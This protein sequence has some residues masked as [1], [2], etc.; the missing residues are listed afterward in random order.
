MKRKKPVAPAPVEKTAPM[1]NAA[2]EKKTGDTIQVV[3]FSVLLFLAMIAQTG[4]MALILTALALVAALPVGGGLNRLRG[5]WS[6]PVL[7]LLLFAVMNGLAAIY[8]PFDK[9]AVMEFYKILSAV[10]LSVILLCRFEKKHV[11]G[12]LWGVCAVCAA[13]ALLCIDVGAGRILFAPFNALANLFGDDYRSVLAASEG[14]RNNGIYNDANITGGIL[15]LATLLGAYLVRTTETTR[16]KV[17]ACLLLGCTAMGLLL[18]MS[19]GALLCFVLSVLVYLAV[20]R[21]QRLR[22][23]LQWAVTA[24]ALVA[25]GLPAMVLMGGSSLPLLLALLCGGV[26]FLLDWALGDRLERVLLAHKKPAW[27]GAVVLA[28]VCVAVCVAAFQMTEPYTHQDGVNFDRA[29]RLSAGE[30]TISGDWDERAYARI[31]TATHEQTLTN[32]VELLFDGEIEQARFV[33]AEDGY[34]HFRLWGPAGTQLREVTLSDGTEIPLQYTLIPE[35]IISRMQGGLFNSVSFL[36]RAQY[37][38]DALTLFAQSPLMGH[39][40]AS[41]EGLYRSVQPFYYESIYVHN[42]VLQIMSDMGLLGLAAFLLVL[43]GALW[44]LLQRL[45]TEHDPL[46]AVLIAC[47]VMMNAHGLMEINFSIQAFQ[48]LA[49][50]LLLLPVV[51]YAKPLAQG[52]VVKWVSLLTAVLLWL[53]LA[54]FGFLVVRHQMVERESANLSTSIASNFMSST[55]RFVKQDVFVQEQNKLNFIANAVILQNPLYQSNMNRWV[56][57]LREGGTYTACSGLAKHYYLPLGQYG[58]MFE[59]SR[60]GIAQVASSPD[61]WNL[62]MNFYRTEVLPAMTGE[63][64]EIYLAGVQALDEA[65]THYNAGRMEAVSLNEENAKFLQSVSALQKAGIGGE[66]ALMLLSAIGGAA[67]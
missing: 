41:T 66:E 63:T 22:L 23:F 21:G 29:V 40:L 67:G 46:A 6:I 30:Y 61:G 11:R 53:Y 64:M 25:T 42:H 38:K 13:I 47:W 19:R 3:L 35:M 17:I 14:L 50:L 9:D 34:V 24:V 12:L 2:P 1:V 10:S 5:V 16:N 39:G 8:S 51:L 36:L 62:Q 15:G 27:I 32:Q 26:I 60:E 59:C 58:E 54:V 28:A 56:E 7:G 43:I 45:R 55:Q 4:R 18:S 52:T 20:A 57:D 48:C 49:F 44:M 37:M 33:V 31:Y 65:L